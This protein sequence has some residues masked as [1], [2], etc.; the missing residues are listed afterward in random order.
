MN[1]KEADIIN[2]LD[3]VNPD[4]KQMI[5]NI[6][7]SI[8]ELEIIHAFNQITLDFCSIIIAITKKRGEDHKYKI[9]GY[10]VLFDN[11][12]KMNVKM[13]IDQFTMVILR[14]APEIYS[15]NEDCFLNMSIPDKKLEV[16]NDF[17]FI[18]SEMFKSLWKV[19]DVADKSSVKEKLILLTTYA[20]AYL[21]KTVLAKAK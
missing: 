9:A 2:A 20:H 11:A 6:S 4:T 17:S 15:E 12:I 5:W 21:Y 13:P 10:K 19:L 14:F 1:S 7:R 16:G 8:S 18:R 3:R